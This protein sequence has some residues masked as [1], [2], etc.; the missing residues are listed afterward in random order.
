MPSG[1]LPIHQNLSL[2]GRLL[3]GIRKLLLRTRCTISSCGFITM[4]SGQGCG[5]S[6]LPTLASLLQMWHPSLVRADT[7]S[8]LCWTGI[9]GF[10]QILAACRAY[11]TVHDLMNMSKCD[12]CKSVFQDG[13]PTFIGLHS[14]CDDDYGLQLMSPVAVST[15]HAPVKSV[16]GRAHSQLLVLS[17]SFK[18]EL[19]SLKT[20]YQSLQSTY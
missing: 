5:A 19:P 13:H 7:T 12:S 3:R 16:P 10:A 15:S 1:H 9:K 2:A 14:I 6:T 18:P 11:F 4:S 8:V 20:A 17:E